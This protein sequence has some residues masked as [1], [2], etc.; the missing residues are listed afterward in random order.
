MSIKKTVAIAAAAGALAAVAMPAMAFESEFHGSYTLQYFLSNYETGGGGPILYGAPAATATTPG[1]VKGFNT[2]ENLK[3]NNFFEQRARINYNAKASDDLKLVTWFEID[4]RFGDAAQSG[5]TRNSGGGMDADAV[6]LETKNVYLQFKVPATP[7]TMKVGIQNWTD[8]LKGIFLFVGDLAGVHTSTK[9]G[10]ATINAAYFRGWDN[11]FSLNTARPRGM[12]NLDFGVVE[13]KFALSKDVNLG[14]LYYLYADGRANTTPVLNLPGAAVGTITPANANAVMIHTMGLTGDAKLGDLSLSGF[15]AYQFG[16]IKGFAGTADTAYQNAVALN[17]A[18]KA[19][20]GPGTFRTA[21]LF[22]SGNDQN[23]SDGKSKHLTGWYGVQYTPPLNAAASTGSNMNSWTEGQMMLLD[24]GA[25]GY[26]TT[27]AAIIYNA[28]NG[29]TM[30]NQQGQFCLT[31]G[32]DLNVTPKFYVNS[33][34]GV[35]WA[36]KTNNLKPVDNATG[37]KNGTNFIG[38]EINTEIGY[39]LYD[40]LTANVQL[41][42]VVLGGYFNGALKNGAG[43]ATDPENPYTSRIGLR[44]V[45]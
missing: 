19:P 4:S 20:I 42:Y 9:V 14:A 26:A 1:V 3:M 25:R 23:A 31:A 27:D 15:A 2:T 39:K 36:A 34:L 11:S 29:T 33:N 12:D 17:L 41:G 28:G 22:T 5:A 7:T 37:G 13:G 45:F 16:L 40:N 6:N 32:Y 8:S 18:A 21:A 38:T 35:A 43:S 24:K 44:Y 10:P 30:A